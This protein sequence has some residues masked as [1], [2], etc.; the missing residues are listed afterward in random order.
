DLDVKICQLVKLTR[1][2]EPV[3]MSKRSGSFVTLRDVVD[4]VGKDVVRFIMLTRKNDAHL[5]FD[6]KK[7]T[8]QSK[9][10]P[11]FY[12]QYAHA[13]AHSVLRHAAEALP[14]VDLSPELLVTADLASLTDEAEIALIKLLAA[15]PRI[16]VGA[17]E[18][19]EPHRIAYYLGEV[20]A[21]FHSLWNKGREAAE[22]RFLLPDR[23]DVSV[24]RVALVR[25]MAAVVASGLM[26][27]GVAPVEEM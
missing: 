4:E 24:A 21:A 22:L 8:E 13:R 1:G 7:V 9:D 16:V 26:V 2:G 3:K 12:V 17:A 5:D 20:A 11:V 23:P 14:G 19:H 18:A 25:G 6:L 27:L 15:W 10:N